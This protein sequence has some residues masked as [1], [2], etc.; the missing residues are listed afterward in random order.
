MTAPQLGRTVRTFVYADEK[1]ITVVV[2]GCDEVLR[3]GDSITIEQEF[4]SGMVFRSDV[5]RAGPVRRF[6]RRISLRALRL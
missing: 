4:P 6:V 2:A 5:K 3:Q 1:P